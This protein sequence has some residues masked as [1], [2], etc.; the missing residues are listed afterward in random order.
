MDTGHT[1]AHRPALGFEG[2]EPQLAEQ[3]WAAPG[4]TV[5]G[6]VRL[7]E[8]ASV[9][10]GAVLRADLDA[11]TIGARSNIQDGC[12]L[13]ADPGFPLTV[14]D[15]VTVGHRA[16]LHGCTVGEGS[17]IGMG[18]VVLNGA[19]IGR[20]CLIAAGAVVLEGTDIPPGSLVAGTPAKVRREL[21]EEEQDALQLSAQQYVDLAGRHRHAAADSPAR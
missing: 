15:G 16:V 13:H 11:I 7:G 21:T 1:A 19:T 14:G 17:L 10:Y 3:A 4:S 5:L 8:Q 18:A 20:G 2:H 6:Q 12:V 9:W